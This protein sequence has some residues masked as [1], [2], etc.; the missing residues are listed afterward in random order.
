MTT[1]NAELN[2]LQQYQWKP[3]DR[4]RANAS[5]LSEFLGFEVIDTKHPYALLESAARC[6]MTVTDPERFSRL[7]P[8]RVDHYRNCIKILCCW[9]LH[10]DLATNT[11]L[12]RDAE[13]NAVVPAGNSLAL[14]KLAMK[15]STLDGC[16]STLKRAGLYLS[17]ERFKYTVCPAE[18]L[19]FKGKHSIKR[20][21][22]G[23]FDLLG[24]TEFVTKAIKRAKDQAII[25]K[26]QRMHSER[27]QPHVDPNFGYKAANRKRSQ[28]RAERRAL[29]AAERAAS[30]EKKRIEPSGCGISRTQLQ[31]EMLAKGYSKAEIKAHLDG[32]KL[33]I[34][35]IPY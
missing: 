4:A 22:I 15:Q 1:S 10:L 14:N 8:A 9:L 35:D 21:F 31:L 19:V 34:D 32:D 23:L 27:Q 6:A 29:A 16:V 28:T 12:A 5:Y 7:F 26:H 11:V 3:E 13:S 33:P 17:N 25:R 20:V 2:N 30:R 24:T 18:G